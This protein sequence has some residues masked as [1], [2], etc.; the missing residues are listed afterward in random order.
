M[1][2]LL[3]ALPHT[4]LYVRLQREGRLLP[5]GEQGDNTK[6]ARFVRILIAASPATWPQVITDW[7]AGLAM[8]D[9]VRRH[10]GADPIRAERLVNK[11]ADWLR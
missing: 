6:P 5:R 7:I 2:G 4:P 9:Y 3:T 11:T 10:F 1:V 8:R